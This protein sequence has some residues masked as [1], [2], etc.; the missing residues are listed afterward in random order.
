[1]AS[2]TSIETAG[3]VCVLKS[4]SRPRKTI[5]SKDAIPKEALPVVTSL[6]I[7][8][9]AS[10]FKDSFRAFSAEGSPNVSQAVR[11]YGLHAPRR[12]RDVGEGSRLAYEVASLLYP[13]PADAELSQVI[14]YG[15]CFLS[16]T[17]ITMPSSRVACSNLFLLWVLTLT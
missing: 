7:S 15:M 6:S 10:I 16:S 12:K 3:P 11:A 8:D 5:P 17:E 4:T 14:K 2:V 1:M 9:W 13:A